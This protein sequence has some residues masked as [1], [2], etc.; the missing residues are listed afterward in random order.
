[1]SI[2][3]I[4]PNIVDVFEKNFP[5]VHERPAI[6]PYKEDIRKIVAAILK[7]MIYSYPHPSEKY[8]QH[9]MPYHIEL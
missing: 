8:N 6:Q 2:K 1:M 5:K 9:Q 4:K 7:D 3:S